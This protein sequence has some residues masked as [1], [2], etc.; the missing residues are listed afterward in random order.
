MLR[1]WI[2]LLCAVFLLGGCGYRLG[3]HPDEGYLRGVSTI[4]VDMFGNRS[5]E[6]YLED[7][8]TEALME[9]FARKTGL[10]VTENRQKAD[11]VLSGDVTSYRS[12][13]IAYDSNDK[14]TEYQSEMVIHPIL[15]RNSDGR[16]LWQ[17]DLRWN[18]DYLANADRALEQDNE[19]EAQKTIA[20]RLS[21]EVFFRIRDGF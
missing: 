8:V 18:E 20:E 19:A 1:L 11:V 10:E 4:A 7:Y 13:A 14:I 6:P 2:I 21:D 9:R 12:T 15:M 3:G 16:V 17:G 5:Y